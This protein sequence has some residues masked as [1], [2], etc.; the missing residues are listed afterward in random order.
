MQNCTP[1]FKGSIEGRRVVLSQYQTGELKVETTQIETV[2]TEGSY[3]PG[4]TVF[5]V[6]ISAGDPIDIHANTPDEL[7]VEL[8][9]YGFSGSGSREI[10]RHGRSAAT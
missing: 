5:P 9:A 6:V 3:E 7:V 1:R 4:A 2:S 10:A 8:M